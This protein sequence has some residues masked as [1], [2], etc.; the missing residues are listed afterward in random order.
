MSTH[1]PSIPP[2]TRVLPRP[3]PG[4]MPEP[5]SHGAVWVA[6]G[7]GYTLR[8]GNLQ[9]AHVGL[10]ASCHVEVS[11]LPLVDSLHVTADVAALVHWLSRGGR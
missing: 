10:A 1:L 8:R 4:A 7:N 11:P 3:T 6:W 5:R 2:S 9:L